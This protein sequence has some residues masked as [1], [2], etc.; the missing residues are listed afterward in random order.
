MI[1]AEHFFRAKLSKC[2]AMRRMQQRLKMPQYATG[3][4]AVENRKDG[5]DIPASRK[6]DIFSLSLSLIAFTPFYHPPTLAHKMTVFP[7]LPSIAFVYL[8]ILYFFIFDLL[9][10][11]IF[12]CLRFSSLPLQCISICRSA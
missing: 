4:N 12:S 3:W 9:A 7:L 2:K 8:S 1:H 11:Y 10:F 6:A 5:L